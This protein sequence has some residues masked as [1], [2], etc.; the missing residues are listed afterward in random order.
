MVN[1]ELKDFKNLVQKTDTR[2]AGAASEVILE[3]DSIALRRRRYG[4]TC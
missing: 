4:L 2:E 3:N 1:L